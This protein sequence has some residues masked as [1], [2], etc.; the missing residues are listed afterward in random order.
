MKWRIITVLKVLCI[1]LLYGVPMVEAQPDLTL[2]PE[3]TAPI[4]DNLSPEDEDPQVDVIVVNNV[5][6]PKTGGQLLFSGEVRWGQTT[7]TSGKIQNIKIAINKA[8]I[9]NTL[10][11]QFQ[12]PA[13]TMVNIVSKLHPTHWAGKGVLGQIGFEGELVSGTLPVPP[14]RLTLSLYDSGVDFLP[15]APIRLD[16]T[17]TLPPGAPASGPWTMLASNSGSGTTTTGP[18]STMLLLNEI[19]I[20][21]NQTMQFPN[22]I[23]AEFSSRAIPAVSPWILAALVLLLLSTGGIFIARRHRDLAP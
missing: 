3:S 13:N 12:L 19:I 20:G 5:A 22:S 21:G 17:W 4:V 11:T 18:T 8:T 15:P 23:T 10:A 2:F 7:N 1:V 16:A 9:T 6:V 14:P